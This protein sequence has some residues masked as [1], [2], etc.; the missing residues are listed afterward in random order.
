MP[1]TKDRNVLKLLV[2]DKDLEKVVCK[3][4][5]KFGVDNNASESE[6]CHGLRNKGQTIIKFS[7]RKVSNVR[8]DLNKVKMSDTLYN[9]QSLCPYYRVL[10][11]KT[12]TLYQKGE[13][14]SF[15]VLMATSKLEL[16][17]FLASN[18]LSH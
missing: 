4:I 11:S 1:N 9:N 14:D 15:Y 13:I 18:N 7:K 3:E 12:K 5:T 16:R 10:W 17:K 2:S 8:K 6:D